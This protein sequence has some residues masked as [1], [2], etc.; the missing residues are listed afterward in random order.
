MGEVLHQEP[1]VLSLPLPFLLYSFQA[2]LL[3]PVKKNMGSPEVLDSSP[4]F[5]KTTSSNAILHHLCIA[6]SDTCCVRLRSCNCCRSSACCSESD[7]PSAPP[8]CQTSTSHRK[9]IAN[10][11]RCICP[12]SARA[13]LQLLQ[14]SI[15]C[16]LPAQPNRSQDCPCDEP[17][18][19]CCGQAGANRPQESCALQPFA[20]P[21]AGAAPCA[22]SFRQTE[23]CT[24]GAQ[25]WFQIF[26]LGC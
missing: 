25:S 22:V 24:R 12:S 7:A 10:S 18:C 20:L 14:S 3:Q 13:C 6:S 8:W 26:K 4:V 2:R 15:L 5:F 21:A 19:R 11:E 17:T 9:L 16:L 1:L 23:D